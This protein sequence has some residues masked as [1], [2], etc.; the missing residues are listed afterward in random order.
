M[1]DKEI[2]GEREVYTI[3]LWEEPETGLI[4]ALAY[5]APRPL[6]RVGC[7]V[8]QEAKKMNGGIY[9]KIHALCSAVV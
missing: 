1:E 7:G 6:A 5:C 3:K 8:R 2:V 9:E 4:F